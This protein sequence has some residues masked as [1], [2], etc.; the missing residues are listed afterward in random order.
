MAEPNHNILF[1][2]VSASLSASVEGPAAQQRERGMGSPQARLLLVDDNPELLDSL[3]RLVSLHGYR[4]DKAL[5]GRQAM[6]MLED[7]EYDVVLLDLIMPEVS[8]H[9]LLDFAAA[10]AL[11]SKLIVVSGEGTFESVQHALHCGAFDYVR[12]PYEPGE[13]IATLETALR[14]RQLELQNR[15]MESKLRESEALHRFIVNSSP[16]IVYMLDRDGRFSFVNDRVESLA[17]YRRVDVLGRHFTDL[18]D[19]AFVELALQH[20]SERRSGRQPQSSIEL[21]MKPG[22]WLPRSLPASAPWLWV[23]VTA[24]G[25]YA[26]PGVGFPEGFLG[27]YGTIRD[28]SARKEAEEVISFQAYHDLLTHLP[29]RALL[30]DRLALAITQ[31]HR[32]G[33]K[34]AVMFLDLDRFKVVNDTLGHTAGDRLLQAVAA[35]LQGCL[36]GGDTLARFGGDEFMLL[37]PEVRTR[38]DVAVIAR[39]I[40]DQLERPF[41]VDDHDV[42][43]GASIGIAMYPESGATEDALIRNAD[44]AMYYV[45]GR[46]KH[47]YQFFSD[48]MNHH[49]AIRLTLERELRNGLSEGQ[50]EIYYQPQ[51]SLAT[52][53]ISGVEALV[54]WRHPER[55]LLEPD[56]FLPLALETGLI[57][58][59]DRCVQR[60]AF[61]D[62]R[63]WH[64][65]G[66]R[67]LQVS[68][69][70]SALQLEQE[71]FVE[72]FLGDLA[73][74]GLAAQY[75]KVEITENILLRD[76][77]I[78]VPKLRELQ[79]AGVRIAIDDFGT[80]YSS[81]GYLRQ[82]PVDILK[83][84]RSFVAD[85]RAELREVSI[86][87][88][89]VAMARGLKLDLIAEG[90]E[91]RCQLRY[92]VAHGCSDVQGYVFCPP[93]DATTLGEL[94]E[95][96]PYRD[97]VLGSRG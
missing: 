44:I 23:E 14:Q 6:A 67:D 26:S 93:V 72:R 28:I 88:A 43:V 56:A 36:R 65:N 63:A 9:D 5:G 60:Q 25:I 83:I 40:L 30:K 37:L 22:Q 91:N 81:L 34:L 47:G 42:F 16:D 4:P 24:Q 1:P 41:T 69:N 89:I 71:H 33:R 76:M 96:D 46:N 35:R 59:L 79:S 38:D 19:P 3:H 64:D 57:P 32:S 8:G 84:D 90:V 74:A 58:Q 87:D 70:L 61:A 77:E 53:N 73:E 39:K 13:L 15:I 68:V 66:F 17:G 51:V 86:I 62:V 50:L 29:N 11:E 55:G 18:L 54:R 12:K 95:A 10:R 49:L 75:V 85:I 80:G 97:L 82:F 45:K 20:F 92:L 27:S 52:G 7:N 21:R 48:E 78:V 2:G 31:A 94:L